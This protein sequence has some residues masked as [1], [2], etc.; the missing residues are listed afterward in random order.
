LRLALVGR[1]VDEADEGAKKIASRTAQALSARHEI[2]R[3]SHRDLMRPSGRAALT[4]FRPDV[5]HMFARPKLRDLA[6]A[7]WSLRRTPSARLVVTAMHPDRM[8]LA[9]PPFVW[10]LRCARPDIVLVQSRASEK[11]FDDAG[12]HV[13]WC[14]N[15]VD[16]GAFRPVDSET[17]RARKSELGLDPERAVVLHVGHLT[18][19]RKLHR[20]IPL[21][22]ECQLVVV[23]SRHFPELPGLRSSLERAGARMLDQ[24]FLEIARVYQAADCYV[25]PVDYGDSIYQPLS[26]LEALACGVPVVSMPYPSLQ[27]CAELAPHLWIASDER[28]LLPLALDLARRGVSARCDVPTWDEIAI[29]LEGIYAG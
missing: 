20:L 29:H 24:F 4:S 26:V 10:G 2:A 15:G 27:E 25:F 11:M 7:K 13:V 23:T 9:C 28:E 21:A 6:V 12:T 14:P 17:R 1:F 18:A 3:L 8:H 19:K 22:A 16:A 5:I